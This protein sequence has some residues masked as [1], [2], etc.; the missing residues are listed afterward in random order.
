MSYSQAVRARFEEQRS[1]AAAS[2]SGTYAG[3]GSAL[4]HPARLV[5]INNLTDGDLQFSLNGI[6]D[7]FV[8]A[9]RSAMVL[10]VAS[11]QSREHGFYFAEGDRLYVK[12]I[13]NPTT[14]SVYFSVLYG[15]IS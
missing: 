3:V 13:D 1:L 11:N 10:D 5:I 7:H 4:E 15:S 12:E 9:K 8:L 6:T 14:G 2:I